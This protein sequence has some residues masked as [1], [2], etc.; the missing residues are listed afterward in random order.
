MVVVES[1]YVCACSPLINMIITLFAFEV[2]EFVE[3]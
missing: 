1:V 3:I 2:Q